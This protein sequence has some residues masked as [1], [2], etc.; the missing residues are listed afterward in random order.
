MYLYFI[1]NKKCIKQ[2]MIDY[3]NINHLIGTNFR[4]EAQKCAIFNTEIMR[5]QGVREN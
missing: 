4:A 2:Q 1:V 5:S 3:V